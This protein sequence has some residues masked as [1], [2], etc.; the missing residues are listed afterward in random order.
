MMDTVKRNV[1]II[2]IFVVII[3]I[4]III[5]QNRKIK[6]KTNN[7]EPFTQNYVQVFP[8]SGSAPLYVDFVPVY[9]NEFI[10][11]VV[12]FGDGDS[13]VCATN[14]G[15]AHTYKKAGIYNGKIIFSSKKTSIPQQTFTIIVK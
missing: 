4:G 13:Y 11:F 3:I 6:E 1:I 9:I 2:A 5:Y 10:P 8:K 14:H 12:Q 7:Y 15:F